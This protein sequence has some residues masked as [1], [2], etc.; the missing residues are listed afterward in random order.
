MVDPIVR[1]AVKRSDLF[2]VVDPSISEHH[3]T[4]VSISGFSLFHSLRV[5]T[6]PLS[7]R[8]HGGVLLYVKNS[9]LAYLTAINLNHGNNYDQLIIR[10][11]NVAFAFVYMIQPQSTVHH[12]VP[13]P[14]WDT[15]LGDL[16]N[17][18]RTVQVDG[19]PISM[20]IMGDFNAHTAS[21]TPPHADS[22][23]DRQSSDHRMDAYGGE[24]IRLCQ[25]LKLQIANG[26]LE[27]GLPTFLGDGS[28]SGGHSSVIDYML[29]SE[30]LHTQQK[31]KSFRVM[32]PMLQLDHTPIEAV[33]EVSLPH[34]P[35]RHDRRKI[36]GLKY[37]SLPKTKK[38]KV[39]DIL[40]D[41]LTMHCRKSTK[42]NRPN[43]APTVPEGPT[44][45]ALRR[46]MTAL[47]DSPGFRSDAAKLAE[48]KHLSKER[49][50]RQRASQKK[51]IELN[52]QTLLSCQGK[53]EYWDF[54]KS[55]RGSG[56]TAVDIDPEAAEKHF[57]KLLQADT[58]SRYDPA[59]FLYNPADAVSDL[60]D[61]ITPDEVKEAL[62]KMK[63]SADGED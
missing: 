2:A 24:L 63:N 8:V 37:K 1:R 56:T 51:A 40:L 3:L 52:K 9:L 13:V 15:L 31:I 17:L 26:F 60:D 36:L 54:V 10:V 42:R 12:R 39:A 28:A 18:Q 22:T 38:Q 14:V 34:A 5:D 46:Q 25:S 50:K 62:K 21:S 32:P 23:F 6:P 49:Q 47:A 58:P 61:P 20:V 19:A 43:P 35:S 16:V 27:P 41:D 59:E 44:S 48:Y 57:R 33:I 30:S 11:G 29:F 53:R 55:V 7:N 4:L 45:A